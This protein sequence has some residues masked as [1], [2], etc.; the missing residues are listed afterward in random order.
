MSG[1]VLGQ[2][3]NWDG[4]SGCLLGVAEMVF[5]LPMGLTTLGSLKTIHPIRTIWR[6][7]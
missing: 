2:P 3:E 6:N 1:G 5:R 4:V 7:A